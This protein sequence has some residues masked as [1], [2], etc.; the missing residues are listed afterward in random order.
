MSLVQDDH[1][2]QAVAADTP[3][4]PFDVG[5]L[6]RTPRRDEHLFD[7]VYPENLKLFRNLTFFDSV[8]MLE[9]RTPPS[10]DMSW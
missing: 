10:S 4:Q 3:N 5:V 1:V 7:P 9:Q 8:L 2:V 6:P